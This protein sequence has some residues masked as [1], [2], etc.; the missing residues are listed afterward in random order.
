VY[1]GGMWPLVMGT[2]GLRM[3]KVRGKNKKEG[4]A[5]EVHHAMFAG[6]GSSCGNHEGRLTIKEK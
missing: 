5:K 3:A 6:P 4:S 2:N 1:R